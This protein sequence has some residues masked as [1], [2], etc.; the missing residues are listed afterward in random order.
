MSFS[1]DIKA[2]LVEELP[3]SRHCQIA[4]LAAYVAFLGNFHKKDGKLRFSLENCLLLRHYRN[5][6]RPSQTFVLFDLSSGIFHHRHF[7]QEK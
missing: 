2:E 4:E 6:V 7:Q 5:I 3:K 1:G